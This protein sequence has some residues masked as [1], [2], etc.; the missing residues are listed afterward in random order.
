MFCATKCIQKLRQHPVKSNLGSCVAD[1]TRNPLVYLRATNLIA[2]PRRVLIPTPHHLALQIR[3]KKCWTLRL[4]CYSLLGLNIK[5]NIVLMTSPNNDNWLIGTI[6]TIVTQYGY[7]VLNFQVLYDQNETESR[8]T[9]N[10]LAV[11]L[12]LYPSRCH[13]NIEEKSFNYKILS[14]FPLLDHLQH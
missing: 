6:T 3:N 5:T 2:K 8:K 12:P 1:T 4:F 7:W 13:S 10:L 14:L 9:S 11:P